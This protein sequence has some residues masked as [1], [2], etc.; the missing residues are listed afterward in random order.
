M[1]DILLGGGIFTLHIW[2]THVKTSSFYQKNKN[3]EIYKELFKEFDTTFSHPAPLSLKNQNIAFFGK[4]NTAASNC[5]KDFLV[6]LGNIFYV[7]EEEFK[8]NFEILFLEFLKLKNITIVIFSNPYGNAK[9]LKIYE[10]CKE[11]NIKFYCFDRGALPDSWFLD[12]GFNYDS[13]SY[14]K[15]SSLDN[16]QIEKTKKYINNVLNSDIFLETQGS[17]VGKDYLS[18]KYKLHNKKIIFVPLQRPSDTV[19]KYFSNLS[20]NEFCEIIDDLALKLKVL[21]YEFIIKKHPL[22]N[23]IYSF[24]NAIIL[25]NNTNII[26][27]LDLCDCVCL[28]NSGVGVYAMMMNKPCFIFAN[29]FYEL[30]GVN[31][32]ITSYNID[33]ISQKIIN[34][35]VVDE[36]K[37]LEFIY[38]LRYK[39]YSF[40]VAKTKSRKE[41][42][43]SLRTITYSLDFYELRID[44]E[45]VFIYDR[46]ENKP[47]SI[48]SPIYER[49]RLD[50]ITKGMQTGVQKSNLHLDVN[51]NNEIVVQ[52]QKNNKK[53]RISSLIRK[54]RAN[55]Y[56][57]FADSKYKIINKMKY[58][59]KE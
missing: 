38:F 31:Y 1:L 53:R 28:L 8:N 27:A 55:P 59:F 20:M 5:I 32:K 54:F 14:K 51:T 26:D 52:I 42:D 35:F 37:V 7:Y 41:V 45:D 15:L 19:I 18:H 29:A 34:S 4:E 21:G 46:V 13:K 23:E 17:R 10:Y 36:A 44:G 22:E 56:M 48:T 2:H 9:R 25:D 33:E 12:S 39:F 24:K 6:H 40:A 57:F 50:L 47:I 49:F 11:N 43:N 3:R 30:D 16:K 58:F